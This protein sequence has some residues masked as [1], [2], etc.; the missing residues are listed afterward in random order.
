[1]IG[2][3]LSRLLGWKAD[4]KNPQLEV[5]LFTVSKNLSD[6]IDLCPDNLKSNVL[7]VFMGIT[8]DIISKNSLL[9]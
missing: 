8:G 7:Y 3:G 1:M 2:V 4:L 5:N 9:R 6:Y